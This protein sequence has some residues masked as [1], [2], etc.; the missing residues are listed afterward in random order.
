MN[1]PA[2]FLVQDTFS[3]VGRGTIATGVVLKGI[4]TKGMKTTINNKQSEVLSI[5]VPKNTL[6][7]LTPGIQAGL[8]LKDIKIED[9]HQGNVIN[10]Q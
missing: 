9:I 8:L 6:D 7:T 3:I 1:F 4:V 5:E 2:S 10:F